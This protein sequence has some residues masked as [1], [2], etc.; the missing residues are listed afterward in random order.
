V[1]A[2]NCSSWTAAIAGRSAQSP[3][4]NLL[5]NGINRSSW[6]AAGKMSESDVVVAG[7]SPDVFV[8]GIIK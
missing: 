1:D 7:R 6:T 3:H 2:I 4:A 5:A 8:D